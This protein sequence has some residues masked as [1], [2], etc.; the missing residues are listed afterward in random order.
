MI[1]GA[2]VPGLRP[3]DGGALP[4]DVV[5]LA[6]RLHLQPAAVASLADNNGQLATSTAARLE[7]AAD[8]SKALAKRL[9]L[10]EAQAQSLQ[11]LFLDQAI[12]LGQA[13]KSGS[14]SVE[15]REEITLDTLDGVR[16]LVGEGGLAAAK[17]ELQ[18]LR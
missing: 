10:D 1:V 14:L 4:A 16:A 6:A 13:E 7:D 9:H 11:G 17:A 15:R 2:Q 5:N 3:A 18:Q 8:R 12:A